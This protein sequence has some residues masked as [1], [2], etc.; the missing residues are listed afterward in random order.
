VRG[1]GFKSAGRATI[2]TIENIL[3]ELSIWASY[4]AQGAYRSCNR[5]NARGARRRSKDGWGSREPLSVDTEEI[6]LAE[7]A[8]IRCKFSSES[9]PSSLSSDRRPGPA[10][11]PSAGFSALR[12][13]TGGLGAPQAPV[14]CPPA[15]RLPKPLSPT[16]CS[17]CQRAGFTVKAASGVFTVGCLGAPN[18]APRLL[19]VPAFGKGPYDQV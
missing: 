18:S 8:R 16:A 14:L 13:G 4:L 15:F 10:L 6:R 11:P 9:S 1:A 7:P 3:G 19:E 2:V 12:A 17:V 5:A